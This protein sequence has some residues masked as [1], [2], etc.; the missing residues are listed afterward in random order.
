LRKA[1]LRKKVGDKI[2]VESLDG[3]IEGKILKI[4]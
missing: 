3:K 1:L 2:K 4:E